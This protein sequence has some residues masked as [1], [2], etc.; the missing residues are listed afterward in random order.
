MFRTAPRKRGLLFKF[1]MLELGLPDFESVLEGGDLLV[2]VQP[3][4]R[5]RHPRLLVHRLRL[6]QYAGVLS[7]ADG[8][9]DLGV[10]RVI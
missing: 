1:R 5:G 2:G 6:L 10:D 4:P 7:L 3:D 8:L 9:R